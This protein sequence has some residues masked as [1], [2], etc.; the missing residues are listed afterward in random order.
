MNGII[1]DGLEPIV[2]LTILSRNGDAVEVT[3]VVN[4]GST[5]E[6]TLPTTAI[7]DLELT[8]STTDRVTLADGSVANC[9]VYQAMIDW[10]GQTRT[11]AVYEMDGAPLLGMELMQGCRLSMDVLPDGRLEISPLADSQE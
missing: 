11:I 9:E 4:T 8:W 3:V 7:R 2:V 5:G 10:F 1:A 6:L